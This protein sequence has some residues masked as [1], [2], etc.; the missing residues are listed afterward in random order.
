MK[1]L[2]DKMSDRWK[3]KY[4]QESIKHLRAQQTAIESE[5]RRAELE[6]MIEKHYEQRE[7]LLENC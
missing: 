7:K 1:F 6:E 3:V 4:H 2:Y 5:E